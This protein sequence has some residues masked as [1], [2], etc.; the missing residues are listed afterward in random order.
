[1]AELER[2]VVE[3]EL[4]LSTLQQALATFEANCVRIVGKRYAI[5]DELSAKISEAEA[6]KDPDDST[7]Q[8]KAREARETAEGSASEGES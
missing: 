1:M 4:D 3:R 6:R 8:Q 7:I 2:D 5:L